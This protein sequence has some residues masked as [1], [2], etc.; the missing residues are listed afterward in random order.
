MTGL[1]LFGIGALALVCGGILYM[2]SSE[3]KNIRRAPGQ[4]FEKRILRG[5]TGYRTFNI[6][7]A[8]DLPGGGRKVSNCPVSKA[9]WVNTTKGDSFFVFYRADDPETNYPE[10]EGLVQTRLSDI[11]A[12]YG[13]LTG[14]IGLFL[15]TG[16]LRWPNYDEEMLPV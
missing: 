10:G 2:A 4:I 5:D 12:S 1:I 8:F 13:V 14:L 3:P 9:L 6:E 16:L 11:C 7:Y 15:A